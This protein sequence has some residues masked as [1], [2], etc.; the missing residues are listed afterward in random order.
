M[1]AE[2][3]GLRERDFYPLVTGGVDDSANSYAWGIAH[4][5]NALYVGTNRHHLWGISQGMSQLLPWDLPFDLTDSGPPGPTNQVPGEEEWANE[6]AGRIYRY[7]NG[8]WERVHT[9]E[10]LEGELPIVFPPQDPP[11]EGYYP[12][13]YGYRTLGVFDGQIYAIG[14]GTWIPNMPISRILRSDTGDADDWED[15]TGIIDQTVNP[16]GLVEW[17][18]HLYVNASIPG[19]TATGS[20]AAVVYRFTGNSPDYWEAVSHPGFDNPDNAEIYYLEVFS[21][22]LY[23]STV[24]YNTG[25]E[26]WK[27]CGGSDSR[28]SGLLWSNVIRDGFGDSWNQ[29]GM[30]M[31]SFGDYLYIGTAVGIGIVLKDN[32]PVGTRASD[33]IRIDAHDNAELIMGA[34]IARDPP[35]GWPR[36]RRPRSRLPAGFGNPFNVYIWHLTAY[37]GVL[38]A[39]TLDLIGKGADLWKSYNGI[40][41]WPVTLHGFGNE[42][43]IGLRRIVP[44]PGLGLVIGTANGQ[45]GDPRG[46]F[47]VWVGD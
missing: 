7:Q 2:A 16:R 37:D 34:Y 42:N 15:V 30:T 10:I 8:V 32:Q 41:W 3:S 38:Y 9:A 36:F 5:K 24:N 40:R 19:A 11:I 14:V 1:P 26:V 33:I 22:C 46:G 29:Y 28:G 35:P 23:A 21:D 45:T 13:S 17:R 27:T 18:G 47:E 25:F 44:V 4:Y 39:G 43:N 20:G 12:E 6:L 31:E